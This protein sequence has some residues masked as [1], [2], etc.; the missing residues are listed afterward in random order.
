MIAG[1][2][3]WLSG[4]A[5]LLVRGLATGGLAYAPIAIA[6][7]IDRLAFNRVP[8][9]ARDL[10]VHARCLVAVPLLVVANALLARFVTTASSALGRER[11]IAVE[12]LP[13]SRRSSRAPRAFAVRARSGPRW[14]RSPSRAGSAG[15]S[16]T[17]R[18]RRRRSR[19]GPT[20]SSRCRFSYGPRCASSSGGRC[21]AR[22]S[23]PSRAC[24]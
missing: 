3:Q 2:G 11:M 10:S 19:A 12:D 1:A 4:R 9:V 24:V 7:A 17:P 5:H 18:P 14:P 21:G 15:G 6:V 20:R 23:W 8:A 13:G 16:S 22:R